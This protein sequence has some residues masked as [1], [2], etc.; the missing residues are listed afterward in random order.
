MKEKTAA[1]VAGVVDAEGCFTIGKTKGPRG[2]NYSAR[3]TVANKFKPLVNYLVQHF[4]GY[5]TNYRPKKEQHAVCY[6][7]HLS[8]SKH[9]RRFLTSIFPHLREKKDQAQALLQYLDMD[10]K[11][12]PEERERLYLLTRRLKNEIRVTTET[13]TNSKL[14]F[15]YLS[16]YFDGE[17][18]S[19]IIRFVGNGYLQYATRVT[20]TNTYKPILEMYQLLFGGNVRE[21]CKPNKQSYRWE[22]RKNE[23]R[24]KFLLYML[25]YSIVKR[26]EMNLTLQFLRLGSKIDPERRKEIHSQLVEIKKER[27]IQSQLQGDLQSVPAE[28]PDTERQC[29]EHDETKTPGLAPGQPDSVLHLCASAG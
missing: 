17:G 25:P 13:P 26:E 21:H 12:D 24:E 19:S 4:G 22:L 2:I 29:S 15:A 27:M 5:I 16:G 8:S 10:G 6:G 7:W 14:D 23:E 11:Y 28:M 3:I 18:T 20:V 9:T 1:Y